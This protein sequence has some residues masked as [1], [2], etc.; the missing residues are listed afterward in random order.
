MTKVLKAERGRKRG[1]T[2]W[3]V[4][5]KPI[6]GR[7]KVEKNIVVLMGFEPGTYRMGG[8]HLNHYTTVTYIVIESKVI[9]MFLPYACH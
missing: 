1:C 5:V 7:K 8:L 2:W 4:T 3:E 6:K 9:F